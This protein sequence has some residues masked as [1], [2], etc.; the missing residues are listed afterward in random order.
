MTSQ[1]S[2]NLP[3]LTAWPETSPEHSGDSQNCWDF[4]EMNRKIWEL[5]PLKVVFYLEANRLP[6]WELG[7]QSC[8]KYLKGSS[9][10]FEWV[11]STFPYFES[12]RKQS[13]HAES[14][15]KHPISIKRHVSSSSVVPKVG[16]SEVL[17]CSGSLLV[18]QHPKVGREPFSDQH[19]SNEKTGKHNLNLL[20]WLLLGCFNHIFVIRV[21]FKAYSM[22]ISLK[23]LTLVNI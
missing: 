12:T 21:F 22:T 1:W 4:M 14:K 11:H 5:A 16:A 3:F 10:F 9:V 19:L 6:T 2:V 18:G 15:K 17:H 13:V 7:G 23:K 8:K 20:K